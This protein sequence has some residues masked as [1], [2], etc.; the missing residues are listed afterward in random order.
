M[1][2]EGE[3][4]GDQDLA[5]RPRRGSHAG[6]FLTRMPSRQ[7]V[8]RREKRSKCVFSFRRNY[9]SSNF[10]SCDV[11]SL[12]NFHLS[13]SHWLR[14][15]LPLSLL[16]PHP[17]PFSILRNFPSTPLFYQSI[18]FN[19]TTGLSLLMPNSMSSSYASDSF[20]LYWTD[21]IDKNSSLL[22][23]DKSSRYGPLDLL[24]YLLFDCKGAI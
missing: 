13:K 11:I 24:F 5:E 19:L 16:Q 22:P 20:I 23:S 21:L 1:W 9:F 3:G 6:C 7:L 2:K 8:K 15:P 17:S 12:C 4:E 18:L 14:S 10:Y